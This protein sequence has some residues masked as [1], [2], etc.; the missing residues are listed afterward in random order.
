[1][2][3]SPYLDRPLRSLE[4]VARVGEPRVG[5]YWCRLVRG[6]PRVA[7]EI[8]WLDPENRETLDRPHR[9][10]CRI[11]G[12]PADPYET[13]TRCADKP[14]SA[15]EFRYLR[16]VAATP[17]QPEAAPRVSIDP[18]TSPITF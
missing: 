13:W 10:G 14:I 5:L 12:Q 2:K 6:G 11:N 9:W 7:V 1:M 4:E 15:A 3:N 8:F 16:T 17:G 18:M